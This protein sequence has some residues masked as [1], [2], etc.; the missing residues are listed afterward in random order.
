MGG[1]FSLYAVC[2]YPGVFGGA[3]CLSVRSPVASVALID[4]NTDKDIAAKFRNYLKR[5]LPPANTKI[6]YLD[7]GS[8][9][10]DS[11]YGP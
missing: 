5:N 10:D 6:F 3:A 4:Q 11:Y 2:E 8:L 7:Y 1:L 9:G